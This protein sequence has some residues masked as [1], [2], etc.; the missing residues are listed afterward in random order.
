MGTESFLQTDMLL[1]RAKPPGNWMERVIEH[2]PE[3]LIDHA[4]LERKAATSAINLMK[5]PEGK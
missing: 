5:F 4:I 1:F 2:L 3:V